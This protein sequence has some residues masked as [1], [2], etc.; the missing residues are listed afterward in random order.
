MDGATGRQLAQ[1]MLDTL[2]GTGDNPGL[3]D[4]MTGEDGQVAN[5]RYIPPITIAYNDG[6]YE[7]DGQQFKNAG[8]MIEKAVIKSAQAVQIEDGNPYVQQAVFNSDVDGGLEELFENVGT[9][10]QFQTLDNNREAIQSLQ[11]DAL[12]NDQTKIR[13]SSAAPDSEPPDQ[14]QAGLSEV[15][16]TLTE[17]KEAFQEL[18]TTER[19]LADKQEEL[20]E[21][22]EKQN[23]PLPST[24]DFGNPTPGA[25]EIRQQ[26]QQAITDLKQEIE[27][28]SDRKT[29]QTTQLE[30][31]PDQKLVAIAE[32]QEAVAENKE[33]VLE[34]R[35]LN[36]QFED[37]QDSLK[38][39]DSGA[40]V[41]EEVGP[42]EP[43]AA[44]KEIQA[45]IVDIQDRIEELNEIVADNSERASELM[46]EGGDG[47][48]IEATD[49]QEIQAEGKQLN[50][51]ESDQHTKTSRL[52]IVLENELGLDLETVNIKDLML[53]VNTDGSLDIGFRT[54]SED[55]VTDVDD[56]THT[57]HIDNSESWSKINTAA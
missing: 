36:D 53:E 27:E 55:G 56:L 24:D 38:R 20:A 21:L 10:S 25:F 48:Y 35:E 47:F 37:L 39:A 34:L 28:L 44:F 11:F 49:W 13:L 57:V 45:K 46:E 51:S 52:N 23:S 50:L 7:I 1:S 12:V 17:Y 42:S 15:K 54:D 40:P 6:K 29:E 19:T 8:D 33:A 3:I 22:E 43:S 4:Q 9:A 32:Y 18:K 14:M 5:G 41:N 26:T 31:A 16:T 2:N 30:Q